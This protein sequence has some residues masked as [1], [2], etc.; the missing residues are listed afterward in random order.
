MKLLK[1]FFLVSCLALLAASPAIGFSDGLLT[2]KSP[3]SRSESPKAPGK[4]NAKVDHV[5]GY[6]TKKGTYVKAY[7]RTAPN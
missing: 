7:N 4:T 5:K 2:T 1:K 3:T 6:T